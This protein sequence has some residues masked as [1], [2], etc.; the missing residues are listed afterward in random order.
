[1]RAGDSRVLHRLRLM[2]IFLGEHLCLC[3][4]RQFCKRAGLRARVGIDATVWRHVRVSNER[5]SQ[6]KSSRPWEDTLS[7]DSQLH[8]DVFCSPGSGSPS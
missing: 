5:A 6:R 1:M 4:R 3:L 8:L 7:R 2:R